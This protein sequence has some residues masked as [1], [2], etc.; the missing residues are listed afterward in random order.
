M[1]KAKTAVARRGP[2]RAQVVAEKAKA[3]ALARLSRLRDRKEDMT[4]A[5]IGLAAGH[6]AA[7]YYA[8]KLAERSAAG[9]SMTIPKTNISYG[10]GVGAAVAAAG[11]LGVLGS[12]R[13]NTAGTIAG[14]MLYASDRGIEK[15]L[16]KAASIAAGGE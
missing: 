1:A 8:D 9:Q 3:G 11:V 5:G 14:A 6:F 13:A 7:G 4:N 15:Y 10:K 16:A 2:S 12:D